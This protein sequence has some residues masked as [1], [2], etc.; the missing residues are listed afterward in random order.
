[1]CSIIYRNFKPSSFMSWTR[2]ALQVQTVVRFSASSPDLPDM[3]KPKLINIRDN[4]DG[5]K[6]LYKFRYMGQVSFLSNLKIYL[7]PFFTFT[8]IFVVAVSEE[9]NEEIALTM[10]MIYFICL[11]KAS[12]VSIPAL[13]FVGHIYVTPESD[14][15]LSYLNVWGNRADEKF[16]LGDLSV[17]SRETGPLGFIKKDSFYVFLVSRSTGRKFRLNVKHG[18][19]WDEDMFNELFGELPQNAADGR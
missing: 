2:K 9:V 3:L 19:L 1:M 18:D 11:A 10:S 15:I 16:P 14:I 8:T 7:I 17:R 6:H 13:N 12:L 4:F 5:L